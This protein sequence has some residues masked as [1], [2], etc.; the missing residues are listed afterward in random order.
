MLPYHSTSHNRHP[1]F[2][3]YARTRHLLRRSG[4][5]IATL[6][7]PMSQ[8][9]SMIAAPIFAHRLQPAS[10]NLGTPAPLSRHQTSGP[11]APATSP[12]TAVF[13]LQTP[14]SCLPGELSD[15]I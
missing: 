14:G 9:P 7:E 1:H 13:A 8:L 5:N 15:R 4:A 12:P 10:R 6:P 3:P 11:E 2:C